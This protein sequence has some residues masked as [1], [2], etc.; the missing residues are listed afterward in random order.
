MEIYGRVNGDSFHVFHLLLP[1]M[2]LQIKL[3]KARS[4]FYTLTTMEGSGAYIKFMDATLHV[5]LVKPSPTI[6]LT[7]AN[8]LETANA[9]YGMT[10]VAL[11]TFTLGAGSNSVPIDNAPL[12]TLLFAMMR[13]ANFAGLP[14][15]NPYS[16]R[17]F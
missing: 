14:N 11:K 8:Y 5:R 16:F 10:S 4:D 17:H 2:Q 3:T 15:T 13:N 7:H 6:R 12:G 9:R 1:G